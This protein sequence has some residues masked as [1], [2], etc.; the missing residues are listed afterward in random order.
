MSTSPHRIRT[1]YRIAFLLTATLVLAIVVTLPF[2]VASIVD[3][4]LGPS[5][6]AVTPVV[7]APPEGNAG[8]HSRTHLA[9][10]SLDEVSLSLTLRI[11]G[12][13]ICRSACDSQHRLVIASVAADDADAEGMPPSATVTLPAPNEAFSQTFTLPV[14]GR[15]IHYPFDRFDLLLGMALEIVHPDGRV[16]MVPA[17]E[18]RRRVRLTVQE[19]LPRQTMSP[20]TEVDPATI[21]SEGDPLPYFEAFSVYFERPRHLRVL[22]VLLVVLIAAAAA[23]SVLLRPVEEL[24]VNSGAMVLGVWGI[25]AILVPA[26]LYFLTA[27][28]LALSIV[29]I[30]L[31]GA[32]TFRALVFVHDRGDLNVLPRARRK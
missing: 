15:P 17:A 7:T 23:Y 14:R 20:I 8:E 28:D 26:N 21:R 5:H 18:A 19:L 24:F 31:L 11:S 9:F 3:A 22:A 1:G 2:S 32:L 29:I 30:F 6:G 4:L 12:H 16:E 25:R 27:I 13:Y 10:V